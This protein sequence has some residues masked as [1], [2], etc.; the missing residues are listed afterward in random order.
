MD[1]AEY[2]CKLFQ[3]C[4]CDVGVGDLGYGA[5]QVKTIQNGGSN[6]VSGKLFLGVGREKFF[7]CRSISN[8]S[9]P[10]QIHSDVV[11]EHGEENGRISIDKTT[12]IQRFIDLLETKIS[13][14]QRDDSSKRSKLMIPFD[15]NKEYE[16]DWL[17]SELTS[18][19]RKDLRKKDLDP[20][21]NAKKEF[22]HPKD[23][24]MSIIYALV[25]LEQNPEWFWISA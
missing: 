16:T 3:E 18:L 12:L 20:R 9:K 21:Q 14:P 22:N 10:M 1:Q 19:T 2:I 15:A 25:G 13:H 17:V 4:N 23:S 5:I 7:G 6:R 11:D 8:E 24:M